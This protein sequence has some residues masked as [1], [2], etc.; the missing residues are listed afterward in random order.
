MKY[1][2]ATTEFRRLLMGTTKVKQVCNCSQTCMYVL[3]FVV[4]SRAYVATSLRYM[5][6]AGIS[7]SI[8]RDTFYLPLHTTLPL[9][10]S[11]HLPP[12]CAACDLSKYHSKTSKSSYVHSY[13]V[14]NRSIRR[15]LS[16]QI[17]I[18]K[19]LHA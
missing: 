12:I 18:G 11:H 10:S 1:A 8:G 3:H 14:V 16:C 4:W 2:Q 17:Y 15:Y 19:Y 6:I 5:Y 7:E 13:W 9:S